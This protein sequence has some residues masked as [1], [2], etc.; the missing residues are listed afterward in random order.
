M[1]K[2]EDKTWNHLVLHTTGGMK[3]EFGLVHFHKDEPDTM[4]MHVACN[5]V[6]NVRTYYR[7]RLQV[8]CFLSLYDEYKIESMSLFQ[9]DVDVRTYDIKLRRINSG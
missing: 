8:E 9:D 6:E 5:V 3:V 7:V 1:R 2:Q 4:V